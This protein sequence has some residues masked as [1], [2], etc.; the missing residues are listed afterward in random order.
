MY[1]LLASNRQQSQKTGLEIRAL[2]ETMESMMKF[3]NERDGNYDDERR[4][5]WMRKDPSPRILK[6]RVESHSP[7]NLRFQLVF[8][9]TT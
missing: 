8:A 2:N 9:L 4:G 5:F 1:T 6:G 7:C 3:G